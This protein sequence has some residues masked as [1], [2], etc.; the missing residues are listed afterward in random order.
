MTPAEAVVKV[1]EYVEQHGLHESGN[2][3]FRV[4][5]L[6]RPVFG[7]AS[8]VTLIDAVKRLSEHLGLRSE[9]DAALEKVE[10]RQD[11]DIETLW[12]EN[13]GGDEYRL[14]NVPFFAYGMSEDDVV[15]TQPQRDAFPLVTR[16]LRKS[17]NRTVRVMFDGGTT[18]PPAK[19]LLAELQLLGCTWEG[20][21]SKLIAV[22]VPP[23]TPLERVAATLTAAEATWEY[24]DPT[25][26]QLF[27]EDTDS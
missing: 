3:S 5:D 20:A 27:P 26:A 10:I 2:K 25:Y 24:V 14:K 4:D 12:A 1:W 23:G 18:T 15:E 22:T 8:E 9:S 19:K 13:L 11:D 17:G 6:L 16:V 21:Y 7:P